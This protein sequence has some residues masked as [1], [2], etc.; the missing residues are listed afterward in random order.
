VR[1]RRTSRDRFMVRRDTFVDAI[2]TRLADSSTV[3]PNL[4]EPN[5]GH[6]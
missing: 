3:K 4:P 2:G 6:R 5:S 1:L